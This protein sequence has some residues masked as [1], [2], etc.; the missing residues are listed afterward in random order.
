MRI[1][2]PRP[3]E[4]TCVLST[5]GLLLVQAW[6]GPL[7]PPQ[8]KA[9]PEH[10]HTT[11]A[12]GLPEPAGKRWGGRAWPGG[13]GRLL[14]GLVLKAV[15]RGIDRNILGAG[16]SAHS[17]TGTATWEFSHVREVERRLENTMQEQR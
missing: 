3:Q 13:W 11:Q 12:A 5:A 4:V 7:A 2:V 10:I 1:P 16:S 9:W 14:P 17:K 6:A 8:G 15:L